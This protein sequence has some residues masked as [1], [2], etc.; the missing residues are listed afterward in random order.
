VR[1]KLAEGAAAPRTREA[2]SLQSVT[3][4]VTATTGS[5]PDAAPSAPEPSADATSFGFFSRDPEP[6]TAPEVEL[7]AGEPAAPKGNPFQE[8]AKK[9]V[10]TLGHIAS[11]AASLEVRTFVSNPS[12]AVPV[13]EDIFAQAELRAWTRIKIDG[14]IDACVPQVDG[15]VDTALWNLHVDLVKQALAHRAEMIKLMLSTLGGFFKP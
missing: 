4:T 5:A 12:S 14:D 8:F 2:L 10:D 9:V 7:N 11:D 1:L 15:Q 6:A 3:V 13:T